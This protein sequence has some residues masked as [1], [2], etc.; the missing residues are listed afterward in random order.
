M[1]SPR[2]RAAH[3]PASSLPS[4]RAAEV[5]SVIPRGRAGRRARMRS[6]LSKRE[7]SSRSHRPAASLHS[8][9]GAAGGSVGS[10]TDAR[11]R[12]GWDAASRELERDRPAR[13]SRRRRGAPSRG[14][15]WIG[16]SAL[17][18]RRRV[19]DG[20]DRRPR[21][22]GLGATGRLW[23][24]RLGLLAPADRHLP[25]LGRLRD[26]DRER[27]HAELAVGLHVFGVE[28]VAEEDLAGVG[29]LRPLGDD[30]L[31]ALLAAPSVAQL[32]RSGHSARRSARSTPARRP[33]GR[34][35]R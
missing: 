21:R 35:R 17:A 2:Q 13:P 24:D 28:R 31:V 20:R 19:A 8:W 25:R 32:A 18:A 23:L 3:A 15:R 11:E 9:P 22:A 10:G 6:R 34:T 33:G 27:Q 12:G 5:V 7:R 1:S 16:G 26:R 30:Q 29:P 14:W 4:H